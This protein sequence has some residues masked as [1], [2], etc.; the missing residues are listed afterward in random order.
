MYLPK[1]KGKLQLFQLWALHP[2]GFCEWSLFSSSSGLFVHNIYKCHVNYE[3]KNSFSDT[4]STSFSYTRSDKVKKLL[5]FWTDVSRC[6]RCEAFSWLAAWLGCLCIGIYL[7]TLLFT[8]FSLHK[9]EML[10]MVREEGTELSATS[11]GLSHCLPDLRRKPVPYSG[12]FARFLDTIT[13]LRLCLSPL[14]SSWKRI[15]ANFKIKVMVVVSPAAAVRSSQPSF[16]VQLDITLKSWIKMETSFYRNS[17]KP[18]KVRSEWNEICF[19]S[20]LHFL[21]RRQWAWCIFF[22]LQAGSVQ[23]QVF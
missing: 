18:T 17:V 6:P 11:Q 2:L 19:F 15:V 5:Y 9:L 10:R 23:V 20:L 7:S 8:L 21:L 12:T 13:F 22:H 1:E 16:G 3:M 4:S 14:P